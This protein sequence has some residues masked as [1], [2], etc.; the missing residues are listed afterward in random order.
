MNQIKIKARRPPCPWGS[1][2]SALLFL[3]GGGAGDVAPKLARWP[4]RNPAARADA[5]G[6]EQLIKRLFDRLVHT[7]ELVSG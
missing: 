5:S 2:Q 3:I 1:L 4:A 7:I 6:V